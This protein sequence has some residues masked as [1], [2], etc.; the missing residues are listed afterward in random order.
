MPVEI[1]TGTSYGAVIEAM[2]ADRVDG[3]TVGPFAYVLAVQEAEAEAIADEHQHHGEPAG[4]RRDP[5]PLLHQRCLHEEGQ[6][7]HQAERHQGQGLQLR[8]PG[9][10][11]RPPGSEDRS[12]QEGLSTPTRTSRPSSPAATRRLCSQRVRTTR[13]RPAPPTRATSSASTPKA[14]SS[15]ATRR[16]QDQQAAHRGRDEGPLTT[17]ARTA[18]SSS[19]AQTDPIPNTPFAVRSE[20]AEVVQGRSQGGAAEHAEGRPGRTSQAR[21]NWYVD[22]SVE[23]KLTSLDQFYN[24]LR[25]I[26]K[27]LNLNLKELAE[28]RLVDGTRT[29]TRSNLPRRLRDSREPGRPGPRNPGRRG[30]ARAL[31]SGC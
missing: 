19:L 30:G 10:G 23:L 28:Q 8:R 15:G 2:R 6:R 16:R 25:D 14:R 27:L 9:L 5:A 1:F 11:L 13:L 4:V 24:P 17:P 18:A 21:K 3:M 29:T 7:H 20:P 26:A 12:D 31:R 22:P